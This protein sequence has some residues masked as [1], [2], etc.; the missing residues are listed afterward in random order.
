[1]V[2][3]GHV[4]GQVFWRNHQRHAG[5]ACGA[6]DMFVQTLGMQV[7][8]DLPT[9]S[10]DSGEDGAP[11][12]VI[13]FGHACF[14]MDAEIQ[15][16]NLGDFAQQ[17][18]DAVAAV[19]AM[20]LVGHTADLVT[21]VRHLVEIVA[22][23]PQAELELDPAPSRFP[24][25][26]LERLKVLLALQVRKAFHADRIVRQVDQ[27]RVGEVQVDVAQHV[28]VIGIVVGNSQVQRKSVEAVGRQ[29]VEI[30]D[31]PGAV[32]EPGLV[33]DFADE[34]SR[35]RPDTGSRCFDQ[36][37]G[38]KQFALQ[39]EKPVGQFRDRIRQPGNVMPPGHQSVAVAIEREGLWFCWQTD[40]GWRC[41]RA[42]LKLQRHY[43][44]AL[45][46]K[47]DTAFSQLALEQLKRPIDAFR[48][49]VGTCLSREPDFIKF[50]HGLLPSHVS[51]ATFCVSR[52]V[53]APWRCHRASR[54]SH[55]DDDE[56]TL[57]VRRPVQRAPGATVSRKP[58]SIRAGRAKM[59][60]VS[61]P[62]S[63]PPAGAHACVGKRVLLRWRLH[64][65][66]RG[67]YP[68]TISRRSGW[69]CRARPS[70]DVSP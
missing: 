29:H 64:R 53:Y 36:G 9:T 14:H 41:H 37:Q 57:L 62:T 42:Q 54:A 20:V 40:T 15:A 44:R 70:P 23:R 5:G 26:E 12:I 56:M 48:L 32:V 13:T 3:Q 58:S 6:Q 35:H 61:S 39:I 8:F 50:S 19:K 47:A 52:S 59:G 67:H 38:A 45:T 11:E 51:R 21:C 31:P 25:D 49:A 63:E 30:L 18:G 1:M 27:K 7:E 65:Q 69:Q 28:V 17:E 34:G 66:E 22:L 10:A 46:G 43:G 55:A 4:L 2:G 68:L 60:A 24:A 16:G 33:L